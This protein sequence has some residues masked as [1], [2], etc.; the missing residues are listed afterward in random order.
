MQV[1]IKIVLTIV[2]WLLLAWSMLESESDYDFGCQWQEDRI[3]LPLL[4]YQLPAWVAIL[5]RGILLLPP[6]SPPSH[7]PQHNF[8]PSFHSPPNLTTT[9][10][11][12]PEVVPSVASCEFKWWL[13]FATENV[14]PRSRSPDIDLQIWS[15]FKL[16]TCRWRSRVD[17]TEHPT[18]KSFRIWLKDRVFTWYG[19]LSSLSSYWQAQPNLISYSHSTRLIYWHYRKRR[20]MMIEVQS[21]CMKL[22][23]MVDKIHSVT[24]VLCRSQGRRQDAFTVGGIKERGE[25]N[26]IVCCSWLGVCATWLSKAAKWP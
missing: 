16:A 3:L 12:L 23:T 19:S 1:Q 5:V 24:T 25:R 4:E 15:R 21:T 7:P 6:L 17:L 13:V 10:K 11:I 26:C 8:N 18:C 14:W 9:A 2:T 22:R 20:M